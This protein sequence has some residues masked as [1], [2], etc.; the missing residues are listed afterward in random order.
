MANEEKMVS[1][2]ESL[3]E[4]IYYHLN[5]YDSSSYRSNAAYH[6]NELQNKVSDLST[7]HSGYDVDTGTM[8]YEREDR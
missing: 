1:V 5:C 2:P 6:L 8:P 4:E 3:I 7:W